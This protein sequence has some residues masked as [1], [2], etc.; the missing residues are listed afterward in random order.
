MRKYIKRKVSIDA[1]VFPL[2]EAFKSIT[3]NNEKEDYIT[4]EVNEKIATDEEA[5]AAKEALEHLT[6]L[7]KQQ[8]AWD[9]N[10]P[11]ELEDELD[12]A[13]KTDDI[14]ERIHLTEELLENSPY[15]EVRAAVLNYD[16][17]GHSNTIRACFLA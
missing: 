3:M 15:P 2:K 10:M 1:N 11:D 14:K 12:E 13:F 5:K 7:K 4:Q 17:G 6:K 16:T 8:I 9:P